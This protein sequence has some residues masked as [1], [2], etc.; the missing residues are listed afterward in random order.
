[1]IAR[2]PGPAGWGKTQY[3][4]C[5]RGFRWFDLPFFRAYDQAIRILGWL[6]PGALFTKRGMMH[7]RRVFTVT[8]V[9]ALLAAASPVLIAQQN[10]QQNR[11]DQERQS[12]AQQRDIQALVQ[13]VDAV[14]AGKQPAPADIGITWVSNHFVKG[15]DGATYIPYSLTVDASTLAAPGTALY[16]RAVSKAAAA[17]PAPAEQPRDRGRNQPQAPVYP[18]DDV[19][20]MDVRPDGNLSRALM[21]K[22]G[23]YELFVAIKERSPLEPQRNQP[24]AKVG[25]L[26]HT[27]TVPDF[28]G[29]DLTI[30][31]PI[32]A[33]SVE[34]LATPL[35]A[36]EQ[37]AN[38]Y[39]FGGS[40]RVVPAA[41][42]KLKTSGEL[43]MLF[44]IYGTQDKGGVPDVQIDYN[45][46]QKTAEGEKFFNKTQPQV[47]NASTLPPGFNIAAGHQVLG[48]LGV[49]LKSF[50]VGEYRVEFK[51]TDKI[52]GKSLTENATFTIES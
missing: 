7:I 44:W 25:L 26:R 42:L 23:E 51:I 19:Q 39:T 22:P 15:V 30:S 24:P 40:L 2:D 49:P 4:Q 17:T 35:S 46:H 21:V 11:R 29:P 36:E 37:R 34:P 10:N 43:Q 38:P 20:F 6:L 5:L 9:V 33:S 45:F 48:F 12:Q 16:V 18:W 1:M 8:V 31:T 13:M 52:S 41:G 47:L 27:M 32:I 14:A 50:P 3:P 28:N